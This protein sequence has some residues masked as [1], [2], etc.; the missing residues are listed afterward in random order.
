MKSNTPTTETLDFKFIIGNTYH[1]K[2]G[3]AKTLDTLW[4]NDAI[5][6]RYFDFEG[7]E[8]LEFNQDGIPIII[9]CGF[10]IPFNPSITH[11]CYQFIAK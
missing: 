11:K 7:V 10:M 9:D 4:I 2:N 1:I 8:H 5:F 3:W 6:V